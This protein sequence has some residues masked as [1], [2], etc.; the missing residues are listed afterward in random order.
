ML[1]GAGC[2][3]HKSGSAR[4]GGGQPPLA[5]LPSAWAFGRPGRGWENYQRFARDGYRGLAYKQCKTPSMEPARLPWRGVRRLSVT[6]GNIWL[7]LVTDRI[8]GSPPPPT[9]WSPTRRATETHKCGH[10][11]PQTNQPPNRTATAQRSASPTRR[12]TETH[13][14]SHQRPQTNQPPNRTAATHPLV[15]TRRPTGT[16]KFGG[17]DLVFDDDLRGLVGTLCD[18]SDLINLFA[19][20]L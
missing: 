3:N 15:A 10:Q 6:F 16:H 5:T 14:C 4:A 13:N 2:E 11:Q 19:V 12:P 9:A 20:V 18:V 7:H 8:P 1:R 17:S